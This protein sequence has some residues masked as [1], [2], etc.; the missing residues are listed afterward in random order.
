[1]RSIDWGV[2]FASFT[3]RSDSK[4]KA[5]SRLAGTIEVWKKTPDA[6]AIF[7]NRKCLCEHSIKKCTLIVFQYVW[8]SWGI[9]LGIWHVALRTFTR[10]TLS[11]KATKDFFHLMQKKKQLIIKYSIF[12]NSVF[13]KEEGQIELNL[14]SWVHLISSIFSL[15]LNKYRKKALGK[16]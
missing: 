6:L 8:D 10:Y 16:F 12:N 3:C 15:K 4:V 14:Q 5:R 9:R 7:S 13:S 1:M 11:S 2:K